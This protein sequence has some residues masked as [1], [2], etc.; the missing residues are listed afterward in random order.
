MVGQDGFDQ[1][2]ISIC[3]KRWNTIVSDKDE[4][5]WQNGGML[6]VEAL[7]RLVLWLKK[8]NWGLSFLLA[9]P[10]FVI[11]LYVVTRY[12]GSLFET[13]FEFPLFKVWLH[14]GM[15]V[16]PN[17]AT[18]G[19][20]GFYLAPLFGTALNFIVLMALWFLG[21]RAWRGLRPE[22]SETDLGRSGP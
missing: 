9:F 6:Q 19:S 20:T 11:E 3:G 7:A 17:Y 1:R 14:I 22:P 18:F 21:I 12:P 15:F 2:L 13:H 10:S 16:F 5:R 8:R 4:D